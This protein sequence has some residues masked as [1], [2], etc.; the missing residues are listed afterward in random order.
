MRSP[1]LTVYV[2]VAVLILLSLYSRSVTYLSAN[3]QRYVHARRLK[4]VQVIFRYV[5]LDAQLIP[6]VL[7]LW[8]PSVLGMVRDLH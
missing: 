8:C 4:L 3:S 6:R 7:I 5:A 1:A 2:V